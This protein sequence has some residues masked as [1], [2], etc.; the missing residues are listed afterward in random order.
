M[1]KKIKLIKKV[2]E[3]AAIPRFTLTPGQMSTCEE[4]KL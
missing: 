4:K 1:C 2:S 3:E